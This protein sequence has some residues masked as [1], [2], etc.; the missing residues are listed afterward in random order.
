MKLSVVVITKNEAHCIGDCLR[1][2]AFA[3]EVI[4]LDSGSSDGTVEICRGLGARV[5]ITDW[6]GFGVQKNRALDYASGDWV[7]S[8]DADETV[9]EALRDEILKVMESGKFEVYALPR[10]SSYLGRP[11]RH[12]G[13]WPDHVVRL[14][15]RGSARFSPDLVHEKLVFTRPSGRLRAHLEHEA[16]TS[17]EEVI[18]KINR[19]SSAGAEMAR[20]R[21]QESSLGLAVVKGLVAFLRTYVIRAGFLDGREGFMLAVSNAEGTYYRQLKLVLLNDKRA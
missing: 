19:Y 8:L 18:D 17:L 13:W 14:F 5:E 10:L 11:M 3:D 1:S 16:F 15:R 20:Q 6:P 4:V 7:L 21:G 2:V 12:S 9:S